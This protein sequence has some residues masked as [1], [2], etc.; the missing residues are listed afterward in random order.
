MESYIATL[1]K[2]NIFMASTDNYQI[3]EGTHNYVINTHFQP[4]GWENLKLY[5]VTHN[6]TTQQLIDAL[7][8]NQRFAIY[9]G[10]GGETSWADG[11]VLSQSQ[12]RSLTNTVMYPFVYSFACVTGS[13]QIAESFGETWIRTTNGGSTFYGSSVNSYWDEDDILVVE[14]KKKVLD[15]IEEIA[16]NHINAKFTDILFCEGCISGPAIDTTLNYY[17]RREKVI[18][19]IDEKINNVDERIWK[20]NLY[21]ARKLNL[22]RTFRIDNQRKP[23]PEEEKI[24]EILAQT[25]KFS[26]KDELNCGACGYPTCREYAVAIAKDLAE[27]EM[28]LPYVLDEL[29]IAYD[30]LSDTEEQLRVA[31]KTCINRTACCGSCTRN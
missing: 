30:N 7:N 11:P 23:Y 16:N 13:Y 19:Y 18:N 29:K 27:K 10:H 5:T 6:A 9:S 24:K 2:K 14:G 20:S 31:G 21:N 17:A 25:K 8:A 1:A 4:A 22:Q 12:V 3:T 28:C 26:I 15:I